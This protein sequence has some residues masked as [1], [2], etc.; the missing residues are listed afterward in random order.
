MPT[1]PV[2]F[3]DVCD[4]FKTTGYGTEEYGTDE[5]GIGT[6][7]ECPP[8]S[9][10]IIISQDNIPGTLLTVSG[11]GSNIISISRDDSFTGVIDPALWDINKS[12]S[13]SITLSNGLNLNLGGP[14]LFRLNHKLQY[15][16]TDTELKFSILNNTKHNSTASTIIYAGMELSFDAGATIFKI[17]RRVSDGVRQQIYVSVRINGV[18]LVEVVKPVSDISGTLRIIYH[19]GDIFAVYNNS[20]IYDTHISGLG[21]ANL[22]ILSSTDGQPINVKYEKFSSGTGVMLGITP[23]ITKVVH[24]NDRIVG[25]IPSKRKDIVSVFRD[26]GEADEDLEAARMSNVAIFNHHGQIGLLIGAFFFPE[27]IGQRV[28]NVNSNEVNIQSD[29]IIR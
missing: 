19:N 27:F 14:S 11:N 7:T 4:D 28:S 16:S 9:A 3:P 12:G 5:Y 17:H 22:A 29:K 18:D 25:I 24:R 6:L 21:Q 15:I 8:I 1:G 2:T 26:P 20:I 10:D 13:V 23:I